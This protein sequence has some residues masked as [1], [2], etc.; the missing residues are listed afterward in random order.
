MTH[1]NHICPGPLLGF[2]DIL[3]ICPTTY[4]LYTTLL[5]TRR[6]HKELL[7]TPKVQL[8]MLRGLFSKWFY[9]ESN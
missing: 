5:R 3:H 1:M 6:P 4:P 2:H 8:T 7:F 9:L